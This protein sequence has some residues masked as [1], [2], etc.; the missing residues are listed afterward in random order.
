MSVKQS[1]NVKVTGLSGFDKSF[2]NILTTK[3]G[4]ITPLVNKYVI[5]GA[6]GSLKLAI[7]A[8]LPP[9]ASDTFMR[10]NL[11]V[12]AFLVPMRLLYGGL[13]SW[14]AK[15]RMYNTTAAAYKFAEI[16]HLRYTDTTTERAFVGPGT[17]SDYLG[18]R[19]DT[20]SIPS[21]SQCDYNIFPFLAYYR[22]IDDWYINSKLSNPFFVPCYNRAGATPGHL[23]SNLPYDSDDQTFVFQFGDQ[24]VNGRA[25]GSLIQRNYGA[26]YFSVAMSNAQGGNT[27]QSVS[28]SGNTF[29]I[30]SL[31]AANSLQQWAERS[32]YA[33]NRLQDYVYAHY[34]A[35]LASGV[36]QRAILLGSA[37]YPV[38]SKGVEAQSANAATNNPFATVGATYGRGM[39]SGSNFVCKFECNEP[40]YLMV[41]ASL[42]PEANYASGI[43][44]QFYL[45]NGAGCQVDLP[46]PLLE[47]TGNEPI[48][49]G[50]LSGYA[51]TGSPGVFG[52]VP[53]NT[54]YKT[55]RNEVHGF[56]RTGQSL[57]SFVAQ[58]S[59]TGTTPTIGSNFLQVAVSDLNNVTAVSADLAQYGCWIDS[60]IDL[61]MVEPLVDSAIPSLQDPAYEHGRTVT[62]NQ[63]HNL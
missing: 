43:D 59:F 35:N 48:W 6:K 24:F 55:S 19:I 5:P 37:S 38:Y 58:R 3:V 36:A 22:C 49:Q 44:H 2:K 20:Q 56:L 63:Q 54:W 14:L 15:K 33:G 29:T 26:D 13:E 10:A 50:E 62:L 41:L 1:V 42:V 57:D 30:A 60:F 46:D 25:F 32:G 9:L 7:S 27:A 23:L 52:Y 31:R 61:K 11:K 47:N 28:T 4:T 39:A 18:L 16:P 21:G 53:K 34:G 51:P 12:E 40:S 17:L 8:A 45:L